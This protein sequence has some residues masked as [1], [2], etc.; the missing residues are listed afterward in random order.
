MGDIAKNIMLKTILKEK[1]QKVVP[2]LISIW[3]IV[4]VIP[5]ITFGEKHISQWKSLEGTTMDLKDWLH[6]LKQG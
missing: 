1:L 2:E 4:G 6:I 3:R 5:A